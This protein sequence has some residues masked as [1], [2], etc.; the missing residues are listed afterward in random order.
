LS[1]WL[2]SK[3]VG[4][5]RPQVACGEQ[6]IAL[7]HGLGDTDKHAKKRMSTAGRHNPS[8]SAPMPGDLEHAALF[9]VVKQ[10]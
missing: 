6:I 7:V 9:D 10:G 3:I 1:T 8:D 2:S 4:I 5:V